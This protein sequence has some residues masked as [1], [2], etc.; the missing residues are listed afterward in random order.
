[1]NPIQLTDSL[2]VSA[3]PAPGDMAALASAGYTHVVCNRPDGETPGQPDM[4]QMA[5]AAEAVGLAFVR[6]PVDAGNFPGADLAS[7]GEVF[8]GEGKVF[9][10]C[11][12][13]TRCANLWVASRC[14]ADLESAARTA[15]G[16]GFDLSMAARARSAS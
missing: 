2:S 7:L 9:A 12:S 10:Y 6:Y 11:R 8:D 1:M 5:A 3:Q 13:G 15:Q 4:D 16:L 14:D